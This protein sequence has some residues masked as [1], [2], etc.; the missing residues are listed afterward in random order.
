MHRPILQLENHPR[1]LQR[2][3]GSVL[4]TRVIPN[5]YG[6]AVGV[7]VRSGSRDEPRPQAGISHLLEHLVFKG[8]RDRSA[9]E[10]ARD[11]E[12]MGA[13]V[14]A[15]TTKEHT[16]YTLAVLPD[17]LPEALAILASMIQDS[18]FPEDQLALEKGVVLEEILSA[19]DN[20]EDFVHERFC[21]EVWPRHRLRHPILG[22]AETVQA[23]DRATLADWSERVHRGGN[24]IVSAAGAIG[25]TEEEAL[26]HAFDLPAGDFPLSPS[27]D[28]A[29]SPGLHL[30][31]REGLSQEYVE[32]GLPGVDVDHPDRFAI[33]LL[34]NILGGGMSSRLFQRI[35]EEQG[36]V[37]SIYSY[38]DFHRD[39]GMLGTS[40]SSRPSHSQRA[41]DLVA[42]EYR[43]LRA[44]DVDEDEI[45]LNKAQL[46]SSVVLGMEGSNKQMIRIGLSE[47]LYGRFIPVEEVLDRIDAIDRDDIVRLAERYLDPALQTVMAYG[48]L[49]PGDLEWST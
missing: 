15:Y 25:A 48:P 32:L 2:D 22:G 33:S 28:A 29:P 16:A 24:V 27:T 4:L 26:F 5:V 42:E 35:R 10:L 37:Y 46:L 18:T 8:T 6:I 41:L 44:G 19:E 1:R 47:M 21:E 36:L 17:Y 12:A 30:L 39:T 14:D 20:P 11:L 13:Q 3:D 7:F 38:A 40:F 49:S 9:F 45:D 23:I 31:T 34:S 43:R